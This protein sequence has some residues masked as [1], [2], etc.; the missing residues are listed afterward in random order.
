MAML[1]LAMLAALSPVPA[2]AAE[3][4]VA[5][6]RVLVQNIYGR[7]ERDCESRYKALAA[8]ILAA[9]PPYDVVA[10]NEHWRVPL[11]HWVTCD[12]DVLTK[13]LESDGRYAGPG[14]SVQHVPAASGL[15][16]VSGGDSI[17]TL[18]RIASSDSARFSNSKEIPLSGWVRARV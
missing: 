16:Q 11:D 18:R 7:R 15:L 2:R 5:T 12:A 14:K 17:F 3:A 8:R 9:S 10:L 13:A 1:A 6:L 4:P